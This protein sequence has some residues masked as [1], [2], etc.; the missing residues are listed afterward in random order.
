M[1]KFI[2]TIPTLLQ[3]H[4]IVGKAWAEVSKKAKE[5]EHII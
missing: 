5:L 4:L 1:D 2:D 3:T